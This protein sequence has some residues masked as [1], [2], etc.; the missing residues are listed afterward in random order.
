MLVIMLSDFSISGN[1]CSTVW[2]AAVF[3]QC[4]K[5]P[6]VRLHHFIFTWY[7]R[8]PGIVSVPIQPSTCQ[9]SSP[10]ISPLEVTD[11][12][13]EKE[14][15]CLLFVEIQLLDPPGVQQLEKKSEQTSVLQTINN[16]PQMLHHLL[17][18]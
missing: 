18:N 11:Y 15:I 12:R 8:T 4:K 2:D 16:N 7:L 9:F 17:T 13:W 1:I 10:L 6:S 5:I 14:L 3:T